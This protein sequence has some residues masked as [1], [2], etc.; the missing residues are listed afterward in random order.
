VTE[1]PPASFPNFAGKHDGDALFSPGEAVSSLRLFAQTDWKLPAGLVLFYSGGLAHYLDL[2]PATRRIEVAG[3]TYPRPVLYIDET[4][5]G[6]VG[7][8][9]GFGIGSPAAAM[10]L[11]ELIALGCKRAINIGVAGGLQTDMPAGAIAIGT[12]A[13]RDEGTSH[14][15]MASTLPAEP[16]L[17]LT[18]LLSA[19]LDER[20]L[21]YRAG[22]TWTIDAVFRETIA[23]TRHYRDLGVLTVE[24]EAAAVYAVGKH[25]NID[26]TGAFVVADILHEDG[27]K[28][29]GLGAPDTRAMLEQLLEASLAALQ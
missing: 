25:R 2:R 6:R 3:I 18:G 29:E 19:E 27:W 9:G 21:P 28:P 23:E 22:P 12:S 20:G 10:V 13:V 1:Q 7:A 24:M 15:Y 26:V 11:E 4:S 5:G 17:E 16:S 8:I 14:H